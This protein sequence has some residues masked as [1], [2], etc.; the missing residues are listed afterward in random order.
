MSWY[1]WLTG[2]KLQN[3]V[4]SRNYAQLASPRLMVDS[5]S[6][7]IYSWTSRFEINRIDGNGWNL[8]KGDKFYVADIDGD[9][10]D[11]I[12]VISPNGE[13]IGILEE[14]GGRLVAGWIGHDWVNHAGQSG[15]NGW[16]L[17]NGDKIKIGD[18]YKGN[19]KEEILIVSPNGEWTGLLHED[20]GKLVSGWIGHDWVNHLG[21]SGDEGWNLRYGDNFI[22]ADISGNRK[23]EVIGISPDGQWIGVLK[24]DN[25]KLFT[26]WMGHNWIFHDGLE[27]IG[28][29]EIIVKIR[30]NPDDGITN[31]NLNNAITR[32]ENGIQN[33]WTDIFRLKRAFGEKMCDEYIVRMKCD[34]V[35][36][37]EHHTVRVQNGSGRANMTNWFIND[38]AGTAA[39]EVGHMLGFPDEYVDSDCPNRYI[40]FDNSIMQTTFGNPQ[41]RH[42]ELFLIWLCQNGDSNFYFK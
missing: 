42:Y 26:D 22:I 8:R 6:E 5:R 1:R 14:N 17:R 41:R 21:A 25:G 16:N 12:V 23:K 4:Q 2:E 31:T 18:I 3:C 36:S 32:W 20:R 27:N 11:E 39:H 24:E 15:A 28:T 19:D 10:K 29:L 7:C 37:G 33:T 38:S 40:S 34:F 13:W 35:N 9:N 30:L